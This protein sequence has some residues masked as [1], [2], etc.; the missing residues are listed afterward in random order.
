MTDSYFL[1]LFSTCFS[2]EIENQIE[3][4]DN[5]FVILLPNHK[6]VILEIQK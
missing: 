3:L 4:L 2:L 1:D 6:K 5:K